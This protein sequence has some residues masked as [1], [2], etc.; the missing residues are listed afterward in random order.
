MCRRVVANKYQ[1]HLLEVYLDF[2]QV[3]RVQQGVYEGRQGLLGHPRVIEE[4]VL[5]EGHEFF[6]LIQILPVS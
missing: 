2:S 3:V 4:G 1:R 6:V 5:Q